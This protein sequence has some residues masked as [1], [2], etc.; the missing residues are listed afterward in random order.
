[1]DTPP[2]ITPPDDAAPEDG[3]SRVRRVRLAVWAVLVVGLLGFVAFGSLSA[4]SYTYYAYS[5]R[6]VRLSP[7]RSL[8][9]IWRDAIA[10][11][12]AFS[13]EWLPGVM[14]VT[15]LAIILTCVIAGAWILLMQEPETPRRSTRAR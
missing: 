1:M 13:V 12:P 6:L 7:H 3:A 10:E 4:I 11:L 15:C 8:M 14:I 9:D 2:T 5:G